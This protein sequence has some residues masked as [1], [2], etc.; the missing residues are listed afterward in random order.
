MDRQVNEQL[1]VT[2][3]D[4]EAWDMLCIRPY[5]TNDSKII[6]NWC[7]DRITFYQWSEGRLGD[8]PVPPER[9]EEAVSGR[10]D[11]DAYFP[12]VAFDESGIVGFFTL[13]QP[14][15]EKGELSFG[16][17]ILSP[18]ARG[19]GYGK[20][21]LRLGIKFAFDLYGASKVSLEVFE[22]N[23]NAYFCYKSVGFQENNTITSYHLCGEEWKSVEMEIH[24]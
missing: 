24:R 10:I 15:T 11:N 12:F 3:K 4:C 8:F 13:R 1:E 16:Y 21:M 2:K 19:K 14:G 7:Q 23:P 18:Q 6:A 22:N 17:V 9:I 20:Q 5:R